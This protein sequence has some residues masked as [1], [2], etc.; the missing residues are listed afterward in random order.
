MKHLKSMFKRLFSAFQ[1]QAKS[2]FT[3]ISR[4]VL[5]DFQEHSRTNFSALFRSISRSCL[6]K[7]QSISR[8]LKNHHVFKCVCSPGISIPEMFW[9]LNASKVCIISVSWLRIFKNPQKTPKIQSSTRRKH[10]SPGENTLHPEKTLLA[11]PGKVGRAC[12]QA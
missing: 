4:S 6:N 12:R 8:R 7:I 5:R 3:S 2:I 11:Y 10:S 9:N 1:G